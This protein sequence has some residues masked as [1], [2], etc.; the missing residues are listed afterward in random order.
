MSWSI[1]AIGKPAAVR[2]KLAVE[3]AKNPCVQPEESMR[4]NVAIAL[5][6]ALA[7]YPPNT[8]VNVAASGSQHW[9]DSHKPAEFQNTLNVKL[10]PVYGFV[11]AVPAA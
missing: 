4:Q 1:Q 6:I 10:E 11:E 7:V 9:P 2:A 5:D 3:F 8:V